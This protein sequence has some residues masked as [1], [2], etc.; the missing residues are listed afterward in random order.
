MGHFEITIRSLEPSRIKAHNEMKRAGRWEGN[1]TERN[2][3]G[4]RPLNQNVR[5]CVIR[6]FNLSMERN[7]FHK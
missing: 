4:E 7:K 5:N 6:Y 3:F 2:A 1:V